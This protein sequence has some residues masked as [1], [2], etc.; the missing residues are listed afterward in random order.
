M[1]EPQQFVLM[2]MADR[3][4]LMSTSVIALI[5]HLLN[6]A[7]HSDS[8]RSMSAFDWVMNKS[9]L[10]SQLNGT[11]TRVEDSCLARGISLDMEIL[12]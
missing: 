3:C 6:C 8:T 7:S 11:T 9:L 12:S 5:T 1:N 2:E 10:H 4:Q